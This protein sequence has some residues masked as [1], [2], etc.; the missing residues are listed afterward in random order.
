VVELRGAR[1][2]VKV[3]RAP[4]RVVSALDLSPE[5]DDLAALA[6]Q[7]GVALRDLEREAVEL[8]LRQIR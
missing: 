6:R 1:V 3:R 5:H 4:H 7:T 8:A 2:R